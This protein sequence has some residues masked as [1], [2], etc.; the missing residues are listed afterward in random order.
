MRGVRGKA[1]L[2]AD[3]ITHTL[4]QFIDTG[5]QHTRLARQSALRHGGEVVLAAGLDLR[6]QVGQRL[7]AVI[8]ADPS[9]QQRNGQQG[10]LR[11]GHGDAE[12]PASG[13]SVC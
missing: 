10:D 13:S 2:G 9:E 12:F 7:Q 8:H 6:G 3:R 1:L 11:S 4:E 5:N